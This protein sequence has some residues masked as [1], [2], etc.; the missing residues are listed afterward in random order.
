[1]YVALDPANSADSSVPFDAFARV[2]FDPKV[3]PIRP[4]LPDFAMRP[5]TTVTFDT[6]SFPFFGDPD[7]PPGETCFQGEKDEDGAQICMRFNQTFGNVGEGPAE[8]H[9]AVPKPVDPPDPAPGQTGDA[10]AHTY[11]S[12]GHT[13]DS[14]AGQWEW[15][16]AHH[17]FHYNNFVVSNLW[18]ADAN[19]R[20]AGAAPVRSGRKVSFCMED[21]SID[22]AK[23]GRAGV[24]P[25]TYVAP[26][27]LFFVSS[28]EDA[29]FK[30]IVQGLSAGWADIY[31]WYLPGQYIDVAGLPDGDY[32]LETIA[33]PDNK[34]VE[35]DETNNC[36]T[37]LVR[38]T[39]VATPQRHAEI[40][41]S[42]PGCP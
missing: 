30:Y 20:R 33:D 5:Q 22:G 39:N 12:D 31:Q 24:S 6:P 18:A 36:G 1:V 3:N 37:V 28:L 11:F 19:G 9:F 29:N 17:H 34:L 40:I 23:W 38:L 26:D 15:H 27:C 21:E 16:E 13:E 14:P 4:L 25:R 32:V 2:Q 10:F 35:S 41:G 7:P 8:L 42:G